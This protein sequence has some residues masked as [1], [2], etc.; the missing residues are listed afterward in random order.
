[1]TYFSRVRLIVVFMCCLL[2]GCGSQTN[3]CCYSVVPR[4]QLPEERN[5][6]IKQVIFHNQQD[7]TLLAG[8]LTWPA[9][10]K[11][12]GGVVLIAG[13]LES[14]LPPLRNN[15]IRGHEYFLVLS[16]LLTK[17]GYAV[18]RY[19]SRGVGESSGNFYNATDT[20]LATDA[21][22]GLQWLK[23]NSGLTLPKYGFVSH[24][25]GG[26]QSLLA[27]HLKQPDFLVSLAGLSTETLAQT[28]IRQST[29]LYQSKGK[30]SA[31][32]RQFKQD[33]EAIFKI[34]R[35]A[36]SLRQLRKELHVHALTKHHFNR[37]YAKNLVIHFGTPWWFEAAH[38]D[39]VPLLNHCNTPIFA[40]Y[41]NRDILLSSAHNA[42]KV[43][44]LL[45]HPN[46][47]VKVYQGLNH[48]FQKSPKGLGPAQYWKNEITM[49]EFVI[50]DIAQW[51]TSVPNSNVPENNAS[52]ATK[53]PG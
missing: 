16:D 8:E 53:T 48:L 42:P 51:I 13:A 12:K 33:Y 44:S 10:G 32:I 37:E 21:N 43:R 11:I 6:H 49:E 25:R 5:Y 29:P 9:K 35:Q 15:L 26:I 39:P 17:Q 20:Q 46:S 27:C 3:N 38:R 23:Q 52:H 18:L 1:M 2:S 22:A 28:T 14:N 36:S 45:R 24:S 40:L 47:K 31:Q 50:K 30:S 4:P 34:L 7:N 41:G 19:D